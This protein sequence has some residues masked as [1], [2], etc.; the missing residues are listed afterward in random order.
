MRLPFTPPLAFVSSTASSIPSRVSLPNVE[1][2]PERERYAPI[3]ISSDLSFE[4]E[5]SAKSVA[6]P[7]V[8]QRLVSMACRSYHGDRWRRRLSL[9]VACDA[10][11]KRT[12]L[13]APLRKETSHE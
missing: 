8:K 13:L 6:T 4:H 2:G 7:T 9:F 1:S 10:G 11:R 5:T 3:K 12:R